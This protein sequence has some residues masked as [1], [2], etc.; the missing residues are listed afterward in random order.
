MKQIIYT[1][2]LLS[3]LFACT[4]TT[5][6]TDNY[7]CNPAPKKYT[8]EKEGLTLEQV[9]AKSLEDLKANLNGPQVPMGAVH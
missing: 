6:A 8:V 2:E 7:V 9:D 5:H 4:V 3:L 1:F